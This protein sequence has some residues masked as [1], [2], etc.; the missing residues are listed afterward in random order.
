[1]NFA[2]QP[3]PCGGSGQQSTNTF[4]TKLVAGENRHHGGTKELFFN[5]RRLQSRMRAIEGDLKREQVT[6][7]AKG[8]VVPE[9]DVVS[10]NQRLAVDFSLNVTV[11][12]DRDNEWRDRLADE[13]ADPAAAFAQQQEAAG[14]AAL[15]ANALQTLKERERHILIERRLKDEPQTLE[16]LSQRYG[17]SRDRVRRIEVPTFGKAP[18]AE[19]PLQ[20]LAANRDSDLHLAAAA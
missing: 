15:L 5:L 14:R 11:G 12:E 1:V 2:S 7:I 19:P 18:S 17:I 4:C 20:P 3:A 8:L 16:E 10:M 6:A 9:Q 13:G